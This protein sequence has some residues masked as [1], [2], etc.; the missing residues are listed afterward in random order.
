PRRI[1]Q[2][3]G[4]EPPFEL[5]EREQQRAEPGRAQFPHHELVAPA[6]QVDGD[7]A[8]RLHLGAV[9]G[10][11]RQPGHGALPH[12]ALELGFGVLQG[13]IEV[14]AAGGPDP[15]ELAPHPHRREGLLELVLDAE[16]ERRDAEDAL[17]LWR[18]RKPGPVDHTRTPAAWR[19]AASTVF[20]T[21]IATVMGPTPPGT[22][23]RA[24][25][26]RATEGASQSPTS[27]W[28]PLPPAAG[29]P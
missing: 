18:R 9:A 2:P 21:T 17:G 8:E 12:H 3:L 25:A 15:G 20:D 22:G 1:E 24:S 16:R 5:L 11:E 13:E 26:T 6:R 27:R 23:G 19:C 10:L 4:L 28:P 7:V 14:A 29:T